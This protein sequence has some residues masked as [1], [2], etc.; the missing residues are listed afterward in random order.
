MSSL[1][2]LEIGRKIFWGGGVRMDREADGE[3]MEIKEYVLYSK[4]SWASNLF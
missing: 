2:T 1:L 3:K 4:Q